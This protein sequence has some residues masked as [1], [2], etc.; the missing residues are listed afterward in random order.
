MSMTRAS[1]QRQTEADRCR[2]MQTEAGNERDRESLRESERERQT[3][4]RD[5]CRELG[6]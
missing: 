2:H 1:R 3:A 6:R 5:T 4:H